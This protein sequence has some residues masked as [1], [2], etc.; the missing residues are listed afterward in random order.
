M[1]ELHVTE[2][3]V[4]TR[5]V[6]VHGS[7]SDG[8]DAWG[9]QQVL[10]DFGYRL[11]L[12]DRRGYGRSPRGA[13]EDYQR[14]AADIAALLGD[15]AHL[16][17]HSYGA[18]SAL[19]AACLRSEA[20]LSLTLIEPPAFGLVSD[21]PAVASYMDVF[22]GVWAQE[23]LSDREFLREFLLAM[24]MPPEMVT[25]EMLDEWTPAAAT[26]RRCRP[27]WE[28]GLPTDDMT[29]SPY[30]T[31]VVSGAHS[32]AFDAAAHAV[33]AAT[34]GRVEVLAG[35]GHMV[36]MLAEPFNELLLKFWTEAEA[37]ASARSSSSAT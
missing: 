26:L 1:T 5:A 29:S 31:L 11:V 17:G 34:D 35:A 4:G 3:G 10:A 15:G 22:R 21:D 28:A 8:L 7:L 14:D 12:P 2:M 23:D 6:F 30:P 27:V 36:Q 24:D 33:A 25:D 19:W 18:L 37:D 16:V 20:V 32:P 9:G 13:G